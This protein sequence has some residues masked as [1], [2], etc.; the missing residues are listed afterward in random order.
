[1]CYGCRFGSVKIEILVPDKYNQ[2]RFVEE[3]RDFASDIIAQ[4]GQKP[5]HYAL[6]L[7]S[8]KSG[9]ELDFRVNCQ[10]IL[11]VKKKDCSFHA[12]QSKHWKIKHLPHHKLSARESRLGLV[13]TV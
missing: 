1:M 13:R 12:T 3:T 11:N 9:S 2:A 5:I 4:A 10:C 8:G 6:K 7:D